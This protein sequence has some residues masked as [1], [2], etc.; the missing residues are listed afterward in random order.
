MKLRRTAESE[1][2]DRCSSQLSYTPSA[3]PGGAVARLYFVIA[4]LGNP[5]VPGQRN[6]AD[7][8]TAIHVAPWMPGSTLGS[9]P[10]AGPAM[11][12]VG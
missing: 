5:L 12:V 9:S 6:S 11:T 10:R 8:G 4:G 7:P 2:G 1:F 3:E